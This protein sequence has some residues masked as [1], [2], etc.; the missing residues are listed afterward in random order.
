MEITR[1]NILVNSSTVLSIKF[2]RRLERRSVTQQLLQ[3]KEQLNRQKQSLR[4][5]YFSWESTEEIM[6]YMNERLKRIFTRHR[7][8]FGDTT[9]ILQLLEKYDESQLCLEEIV[10]AKLIARKFPVF[11]LISR[12][13]DLISLMRSSL[14]KA[15]YLSKRIP[16]EWTNPAKNGWNQAVEFLYKQATQRDLA[17]DYLKDLSLG[18][19]KETRIPLSVDA[20]Y[21]SACSKCTC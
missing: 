11:V 5:Y 13:D 12:V 14:T 15:E 7:E 2:L 16:S 1:R 18:W 9:K 6:T 20:L 10:H 3:S 8:F 19:D 4:E 21:N 17:F